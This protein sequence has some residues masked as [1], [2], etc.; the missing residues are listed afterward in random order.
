M[1]QSTQ[2]L[3]TAN[4]T[5]RQKRLADA[6]AFIKEANL[7]PE[8]KRAILGN[9][10]YRPEKAALKLYFALKAQPYPISE[11]SRTLR[12]E[13]D[14]KRL[15]AK[16]AARDERKE[17]KAAHDKRGRKLSDSRNVKATQR[18]LKA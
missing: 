14:R 11:A 9:K 18:A 1:T 2:G 7:T 3:P 4:M 12:A 5:R 8:V 10:K 16:K 17:K 6:L 15:E 13:Q